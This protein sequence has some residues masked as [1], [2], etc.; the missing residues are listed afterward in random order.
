V[1]RVT[2]LECVRGIAGPVGKQGGAFMFD[3]DVFARGA[4]LGLDLWA[5]YHCGRGGVL[6]HPDPSVVVAAFGFFPPEL[7]TKAWRKGV[8]VMEPE[9]VADAYALACADFGRRRFA[10]EGADR[11]AELLT[12]AMDAAPLPG[13]PL[14]AGWRAK[15]YDAPSDGPARLALALMTAREHRGGN[16]LLAVVAAGIPPLQAIMSGRN[17]AAAAEFFGWPKPWPDPSLAADA[18]RSVEQVTDAL[19]APAFAALTE[20]ERAELVAGL[21]AL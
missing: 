21:R 1:E 6:G 19:V 5:W 9:A 14:F 7:Q 3:P 10:V 18:M 16:H 12:L 15:L 13:L 11:L 8:A 4:E 20:D 2:P 17:G